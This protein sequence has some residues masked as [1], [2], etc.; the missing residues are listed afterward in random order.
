MPG[1]F[2]RLVTAWAA[3]PSKS[4][5]GFQNPLISLVLFE[6]MCS[7]KAMAFMGFSLKSIIQKEVKGIEQPYF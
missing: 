5:N 1:A 3:S 2:Q 4:F 7:E 6:C